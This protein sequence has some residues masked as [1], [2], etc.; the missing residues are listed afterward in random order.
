MRLTTCS[1][2][3]LH[4]EAD[5]QMRQFQ[6]TLKSFTE[7]LQKRKLFK[8]L[9][10]E[11]RDPSQYDLNYVLSIASKINDERDQP[12]NT[13]TCKAF[14]RK[15]FQVVTKNKNIV[16]GLLS[17]LPN[18]LYGSVISGGFSVILAAV[19]SH[20]N[21]RTEIQAALASIPQKLDNVQRTSEIHIPSIKLYRAADAV[22][23]SIFVV[24]ERI[25]DRLS[26]S[27]LEKGFSKIKGQEPDVSEALDYLGNSISQ[28]QAEVDYCRDLRMGRAEEIGRRTLQIVYDIDKRTENAQTTNEQFYERIYNAV[29]KL[30][31]S[32]LVFNPID[33][34]AAAIRPETNSATSFKALP[35]SETTTSVFP[36]VDKNKDLAGKWLS[37]LDNFDLGPEKEITEL[38]SCIEDLDLEEK[39]RAEWIM[40][41]D[42]VQQWLSHKQF[43]MLEICAEDAPEELINAMS[44]TATKLTFTLSSVVNYPILSFFCGMR[45]KDSTDPNDS[46]PMAIMNS[47][48]GQL[49]KFMAEQRSTGD[50][51]FLN[52]KKL[53][54]K[55]RD[56]PKHAMALFRECFGALPEG[57]VVFIIIDSFSRMRGDKLKGN[58]MIEEIAKLVDDFPNLVI[59]ILVTDALATCPTK[60]LAHIRLYVPTEIDGWKNDINME[61]LEQKNKAALSEF[62]AKHQSQAAGLDEDSDDSDDNDW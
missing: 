8:K 11:V 5:E 59:K 23:I 31:A 38:L 55:S 13:H 4:K 29:Y 26:M 57:D 10:L 27:F 45:V 61:L 20:V 14:I 53:M 19:E 60:D 2:A 50:L 47:L 28:F 62:Q 3:G 17:M 43:S 22:F 54:K 37:G 40:V 30:I 41:S 32:S 42:E 24:L 9:G 56:K 1:L 35:A 21:M 16:T 18:D 49:L 6:D 46:G 33:G 36:S 58:R 52:E 12:Y 15:C 39:D 48:N 44:L 51:S 7:K 34:T 25:I